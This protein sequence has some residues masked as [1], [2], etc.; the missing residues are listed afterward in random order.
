MKAQQKIISGLVA[1]AV[2]NI[3]HNAGILNG[4]IAM[5]GKEE[6]KLQCIRVACDVLGV[7]GNPAYTAEGKQDRPSAEDVLEKAKRLYEWVS[8][9]D[10]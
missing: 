9:E 3:R 1:K 6:I 8:K 4:G 2:S 10:A 7:Y 5:M